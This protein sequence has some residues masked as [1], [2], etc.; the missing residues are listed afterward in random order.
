[1]RK[2]KTIWVIQSEGLQLSRSICRGVYRYVRTANKPWKIH[3]YGYNLI[4]KGTNPKHS[5]LNPQNPF[6]SSQGID[7]AILPIL[8]EEK[9]S[10]L[11]PL[12]RIP[13]VNTYADHRIPPFPQVDISNDL[14]GKMAAEYF[15]QKGFR[16]F[17]CLD[18]PFAPARCRGFQETLQAL[19]F[20]VPRFSLKGFH[21]EGPDNQVQLEKMMA[22]IHQL[23]KPAALYCEYD[24]RAEE[25]IT[26][27]HSHKLHVP[28]D[29]AVLGTQDDDLLCESSFPTLSSVKLPYEEVGY[30][31]ARILDLLLRG[32]KTPVKPIQMDPLCVTERQSTEILAFANPNVQ[33]AIHYIKEHACGPI[34][35]PKIARASGLSLRVLQNQFRASLGY[36]LREEI[37]RIRIARAKEL[38]RDTGQTLDEISEQVGWADKSYLVN[39]FHAATGMTP[40]NFRKQFKT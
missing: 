26:L 32:K 1:M 33:T 36:P 6:I 23:P 9:M 7:G 14:A 38:L 22:C 31:A 30:E 10:I 4:W 18:R 25:M 15:L 29:V 28:N 12:T 17:L 16:S 35:V 40:G 13:L 8:S 19:G 11:E 5:T 20:D 39:S 27:L 24:Y 37:R 2:I 34:N 3:R 21:L